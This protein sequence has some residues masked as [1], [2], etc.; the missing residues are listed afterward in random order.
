MNLSD[1]KD[2]AL[3]YCPARSINWPIFEAEWGPAHELAH[4]LLSSTEERRKKTFGLPSIPDEYDQGFQDFSPSKLPWRYAILVEAAATHLS[5]R[6][7]EHCKQKKLVFHERQ[8]TDPYSLRAMKTPAMRALL[9]ERGC[10]RVPLTRTK[11]EEF[12]R[13]RGLQPRT[14]R[15]A[16]QLLSRH[17]GVRRYYVGGRVISWSF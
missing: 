10:G 9:I 4:A 11:L 6:F 5:M 15:S 3:K 8:A 1:L 14:L 13:Q 12:C 16:R 7:H 17:L 2:L